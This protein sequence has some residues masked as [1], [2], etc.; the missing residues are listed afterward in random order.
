MNIIDEYTRECIVSHVSRNIRHGDVQECL[1]VLFCRGGVPA[2]LRSD[3][4]PEFTV[5]RMQ[6][7]LSG[8][9]VGTPFIEPGSLWEN[10]FIESFNGR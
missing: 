5:K 7:W 6:K 3:N 8:L 4:G 2:H 1:T 10:G 9:N